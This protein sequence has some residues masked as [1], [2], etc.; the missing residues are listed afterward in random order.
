MGN[1]I[2]LTGKT[3]GYLTVI[4]RA[5]NHVQPSDQS[6]PQ[7]LCRCVC[8]NLKVV[9]GKDLRHGRVK[10]CGCKQREMLREQRFL[11]LTGIKMA[12]YGVEDSKLTVIE[13]AEDYISPQNNHA[14][15]WRCKCECGNERIALTSQLTSGKI[16]SC[17]YC[18]FTLI[19]GT[20]I[21]DL[22]GKTFGKLKV[23]ERSDDVIS[24]KG[25]VRRT[26]KCVCECGNETIV[27]S[28]NLIWG[29]TQSC[30]HCGFDTINNSRQFDLTGMKFYR[31]TVKERIDNSLWRCECDCGNII[32]ATTSKLTKGYTKSCG[33]Y[34]KERTSETHLVDLTGWVMKEHGVP[35]SRL[36][37]IKRAED[38]VQ[39]NG[40][41][42]L[43]YLCKCECGTECV[44]NAHYLKTGHT[45]SCGCY[46]KERTSETSLKDLKGMRFNALTVIERAESRTS[47]SG[48]TKTYWKCKCDCGRETTIVA[49]SLI[50]GKQLSCGCVNS[51]GEYN[52]IKYLNENNIEYEYQK[53]FSD[54]VGLGGKPLSYDFY[55]PKYN[56][57]IECQG[58]QHYMPVGIF[59]GEK[60]FQ[61][62]REHDNLKRKYAMDNQYRLLEIGYYDYKIASEKLRQ[63]INL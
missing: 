25:D 9:R 23:I 45:L 1:Y 41:K 2:D 50:S 56:V 53:R 33:C 7:W 30:G 31:L 20:R 58:Q 27:R 54:L 61:N 40:R 4:E 36:T 63:Y 42:S 26:W 48:E 43:Q 6:I 21:P 10:S 35:D 62:Q 57:L 5:E 12:D 39:S 28:S 3:F 51:T 60:Q 17:G 22:Q 14:P 8:G 59:G 49:Y 46:N 19:E 24:D 16:K 13:R 44:V 15:R 29:H 37:V 32:E 38:Y 34:R 55:L 11:D 52:L 47:E 18:G